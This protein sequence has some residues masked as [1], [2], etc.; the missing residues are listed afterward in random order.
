MS[1]E[2]GRGERLTKR[3]RIQLLDL[4]HQTL[5]RLVARK[6]RLVDLFSHILL[7]SRNLQRK[8]KKQCLSTKD[9]PIKKDPKKSTHLG[10]FLKLLQRLPKPRHI[11]DLHNIIQTSA[12]TSLHTHKSPNF[13]LGGGVGL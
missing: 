13:S 11:E 10:H 8:T 1:H 3:I 6:R 7:L 2:S 4:F 5:Y 9:H 12:S